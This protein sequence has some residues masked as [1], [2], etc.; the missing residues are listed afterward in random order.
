MRGEIEPAA[1]AV[2]DA[3]NGKM[4]RLKVERPS[5]TIT[6]AGRKFDLIYSSYVG[7]F[8]HLKKLLLN[9]LYFFMHRLKDLKHQYNP[10]L[11]YNMA[12]G[13]MNVNPLL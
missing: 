10:L 13:K 11:F 3:V 2:H 8:F 6:D 12:F 4:R 7:L 9:Q 5:E 1:I